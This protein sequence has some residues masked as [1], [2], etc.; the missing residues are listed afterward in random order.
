MRKP[1]CLIASLANSLFINNLLRQRYNALT[2]FGR[3]IRISEIDKAD[4]MVFFCKLE[5]L[6]HRCFMYHSACV[7]HGRNTN[8]SSAQQYILHRG[9]SRTYLLDKRYFLIS[10]TF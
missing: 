10:S 5:M 2:F 3:L 1:N 6:L 9:G 8:S 4:D 7:P